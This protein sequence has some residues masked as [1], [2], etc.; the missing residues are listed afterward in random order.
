MRL[1]GKT[2]DSISLH[3]NNLI[4]SITVTQKMLKETG[5][6]YDDTEGF[7]SYPLSIKGVIAAVL[8]S[9]LDGKIKLSL[10]T[11]KLLD[12][13]EWARA[14]DG[15]GHRRAAGAWHPGPLDKA[16]REVIQEAAKRLETV[17]L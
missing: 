8:F 7:I 16:I 6:T 3:V 5:C 17:K 10:R 1:L 13:N 15:G 11:K 14:F 12:A 9:E 2:L 4:G